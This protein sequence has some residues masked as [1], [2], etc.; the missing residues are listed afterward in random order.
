MNDV[1]FMG[2]KTPF[3]FIHLYQVAKERVLSH[4]LNTV[5]GKTKKGRG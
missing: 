3:T 5:K 4:N 1:H 2:P